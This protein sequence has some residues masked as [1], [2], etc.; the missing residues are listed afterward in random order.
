MSVLCFAEYACFP[1]S[2][3]SGC[4]LQFLD[5]HSVL[6]Y[7]FNPHLKHFNSLLGLTPSI[8]VPRPFVLSTFVFIIPKFPT[9][10]TFYPTIFIFFKLF[11]PSGTLVLSIH[12]S[13]LPI[14]FISKFIPKA[15]QKTLSDIQ[16]FL[17]WFAIEIYFQ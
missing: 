5:L 17:N 6:K 2:L 10:I 15:V 1:F 14:C 3:L 8:G 4:S 13:V 12:R 11:M 16:T 9:C 7:P